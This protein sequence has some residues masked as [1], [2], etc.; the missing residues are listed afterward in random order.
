MDM[1]IKICSV[2]E[3]KRKRGTK[4]LKNVVA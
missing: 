4:A 3:I 2:E 1:E